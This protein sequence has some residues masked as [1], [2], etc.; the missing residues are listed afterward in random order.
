M[1]K[2]FL[3]ERRSWIAA[4]LFQQ[5]LILLI[6]FVDP[7]ISFENVLY[8]VYLCVLFFMIFLWV[9]YRKETAFYK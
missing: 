8:M 6:A 1:I 2:A 9:R 4:F 3:T 7:S 5:V